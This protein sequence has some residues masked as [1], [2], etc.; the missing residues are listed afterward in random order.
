MA[1]QSKCQ[2]VLVWLSKKG[3]NM[4]KR[5]GLDRRSFLRS[6]PEVLCSWPECCET[7]V[8]L[9]LIAC[10]YQQQGDSS[11]LCYT[12][13]FRPASS[14]RE[15]SAAHWPRAVSI[16][17]SVSFF[18]YWNASSKKWSSTAGLLAAEGQGGSL[19][20]GQELAGS[21]LMKSCFFIANLYFVTNPLYSPAPEM[22][23]NTWAMKRFS[24]YMMHYRSCAI[25]IQD[26]HFSYDCY[27]YIDY[28]LIFTNL[29]CTVAEAVRANKS[30]Y[31]PPDWSL[32]CI[33]PSS[34]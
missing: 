17:G 25:I 24:F 9:K 26:R 11:V 15:G 13:V 1:E 20:M 32:C 3:R 31:K 7:V 33:H 10:F 23:T 22:E 19:S 2:T 4:A 28:K 5:R 34:A 29:A 8:Q 12:W 27:F 6:S 21:L 30:G 16:L 18:W 14:Q